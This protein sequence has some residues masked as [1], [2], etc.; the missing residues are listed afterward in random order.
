MKKEIID[1]GY[2]Y[3][4]SG[5][6]TLSGELTQVRITTLT[7]SDTFDLGDASISWEF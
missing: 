2:T 6:K 7:G 5:F 3:D 1:Q 4:S